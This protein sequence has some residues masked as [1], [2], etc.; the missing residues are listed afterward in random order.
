MTTI[1][2]LGPGEP[3]SVPAAAL[4]VLLN[5]SQVFAPELPELADLLPPSARP[6]PADLSDLPAGATVAAPDAEAHRLARRLPAAAT[7][8]DRDVLRRRAIGAAVGALAAVGARLRRDC[9]WDREQTA[10]TIVPHTVEEAFEVAE[11]AAGGEPARIADEVGDL[12]FQS[13]FLAQLLEEGDDD[14]DL[15][16][17]ARDQA[18]KLI[19]RH[20]HV[21]GERVAVDAGAVVDLW[22]ERKRAERTE[23][24]IFHELPPG[25][26][27]LALAVK[28]HKRAESAGVRLGPL[29][30]ALD[31][32]REEIAEL[33][34]APSEAE[35]GDVLLAAV[36]VGHRLGVDPEIAIR[37]AAGRFRARIERSID[38][39]TA[40]GEPFGDL[41]HDRQVAWYALAKEDLRRRGG[42]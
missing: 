34:A 5:A 29:D 24:G 28:T 4:T 23:Q 32:L 15:A 16:Q 35:L 8:P 26:P 30:H 37:A 39:A 36:A 1:V 33:T 38:L 20:P 40:A 22:E 19:F 2:G 25:L 9:P 12:L 13:V 14:L 7:V 3:E 18:D 11:A 17:V 41:D 6:L 31:K 27:G 21:Y 10:L 42:E